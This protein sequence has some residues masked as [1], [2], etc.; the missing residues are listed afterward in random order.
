MVR[1]IK[2]KCSLTLLSREMYINLHADHLQS[3]TS[4]GQYS[5]CSLCVRVCV[6]VGVEPL[7]AHSVLPWRP[8]VQLECNHPLFSPAAWKRAFCVL[9][10]L[11][12]IQVKHCI[13]FIF[14]CSVLQ[15][16]HSPQV[17]LFLSVI[18]CLSL[19]LL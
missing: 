19:C 6:C 11:L 4:F 13:K 14:P 7:S 2:H 1:C 5:I 12:L 10:E 3:G 17:F 18:V 8:I 16:P 9:I 15:F